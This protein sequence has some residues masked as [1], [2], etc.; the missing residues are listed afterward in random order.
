[1]L[2]MRLRQMR[3]NSG[4]TQERFAARLGVSIPTLRS[5][6]NGDPAVKIGLWA[7]ALWILDRL[8]DID[9]LLGQPPSLFD[10]YERDQNYKEIMKRRASRRK[11]R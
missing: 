11:S 9:A 7:K 8:H 3:L 6:E 4:E 2:G 10:Q 1:M 5:M